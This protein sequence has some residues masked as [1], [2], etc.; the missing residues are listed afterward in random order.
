MKRPALVATALLSAAA[1]A[2]GLGTAVPGVAAVGG[3]RHVRVYVAG[4]APRRNGPLSAAAKLQR[5]QGYL[6]PNQAA[7]ERAKARAAARP[8][9]GAGLRVGGSAATVGCRYRP[10]WRRIEAGS[11]RKGRTSVHSPA[12][13]ASPN[14]FSY[15]CG[16][17]YRKNDVRMRIAHAL[18]YCRIVPSACGRPL[19]RRTAK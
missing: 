16:S 19:E 17:T 12:G 18:P 4:T 5:R 8:G 9:A 1:L 3:N 14:L 6:V 11:I 15:T 10:K 7:Y 13:C 2:I